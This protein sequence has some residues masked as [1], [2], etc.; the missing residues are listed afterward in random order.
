MSKYIDKIFYINLNKRQDRREQ[1]EKELNDFGLN[2]ER[3][4]AIEYEPMGIYGCGMSHLSLL[5]LAREKNYKNILIFEDD[6]TFLVS[7]TIFEENLKTFFESELDY[8]VC[9]LSYNLHEYEELENFNVNKVLFSQSA[10]GYIINNKY[11]ST[12]IDL[13]EEALPRLL[14]TNYHWLYAN[15]II[16]RDYQRIH[17]YYAFKTRIGKQRPSY[18][19]CGNCF[20]DYNC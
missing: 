20:C 10:S 5:K 6:F 18:S 15:D 4:E 14:D 7:K 16:W 12:L 9:Y 17:N 8:D 19:D 2:Y 1:I 13:Y 3:F 11:Y